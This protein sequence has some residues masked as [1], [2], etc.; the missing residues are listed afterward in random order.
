MASVLALLALLLLVVLHTVVAAVSTRFFRVRMATRV[1]AIVY[2]LVLTPVLLL[3]S[4]ML[5]TGPLGVGTPLGG[6]GT[7][8][9]VTIVVPVTLGI[10]ID[11]VWMPAPEDVTLP[12]TLE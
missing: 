1:G 7:A 9:F 11:Y 8:L 3:A 4:T 5:V 2:A 12:E 6:P 10:A